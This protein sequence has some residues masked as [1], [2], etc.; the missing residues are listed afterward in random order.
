MSKGTLYLYFA[1]KEELFKAVVR[2]GLVSPL[3]AF[4]DVVEHFEGDTFSLLRL[5]MCG[6][7]EKIGATRVSGSATVEPGDRFFSIPEATRWNKLR[8]VYQALKLLAVKPDALTAVVQAGLNGAECE[9]RLGEH[10]LTLGHFPQSIERSTVG[11]WVATRASGQLSTRYGNIED[12]VLSLEVVLPGGRVVRK[13]KQPIKA[14]VHRVVWDFRT[15]PTGPIA[16]EAPPNPA[17]WD[18]PDQGYLVPPVG[19]SIN[20][21]LSFDEVET[22][23]VT[24][25]H[26]RKQLM[27]DQ[28]DAFVV[29]PGGIGTLE[30]VVELLEEARD[31]LRDEQDARM[32]ELQLAL[33]AAADALPELQVRRG[34]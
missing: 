6:W 5:L 18:Q 13:I 10:G 21:N 26:E 29:A 14:G 7:W 20:L 8:L 16:L 15:S 24:S 12:L 4:K 31:S 11:G 22:V 32:G 28:S 27:Y 3:A 9:R 34:A 1:N 17:P 30:E 2:E 19:F 23:V 33:L 25:M